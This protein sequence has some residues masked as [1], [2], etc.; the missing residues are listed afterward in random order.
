MQTNQN[1]K[2]LTGDGQ[3]QIEDIEQL[4]GRIKALYEAEVAI[5]AQRQSAEAK[6]THLAFQDKAGWVGEKQGTYHVGDLRVLRRTAIA[7]KPG[8][9]FDL[10]DFVTSGFGDRLN[11]AFRSSR[12]YGLDL[13]YFGI[14]KVETD[15]TEVTW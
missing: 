2:M 15:E 13:D 7:Y 6:L 12:M 10:Y 4:A 9:D 3:E 5:K 1:E 11:V 8:D 14:V